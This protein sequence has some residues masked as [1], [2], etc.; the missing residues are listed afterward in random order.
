MMLFVFLFVWCPLFGILA[1]ALYLNH[2]EEVSKGRLWALAVMLSLYLGCLGVTKELLGDFQQYHRYFLEVPQ[3]D[4]FSYMALF[5]KEPVYYGYT[6]LAYYLFMGNWNLFVISITTANYLLLSYCLLK[7]GIYLHTSLGNMLVA[8]FF[9]AFFFQEFAAIGNMLRQGLAQSVTLAFLVRWHIDRKHS[10]WMALGAL[11]IHTSCLPIL[12]IGL[13]PVIRKRFR[14]STWMLLSVVACVGA[15]LFY[16]LGGFLSHLP[17]VGY[18]FERTANYEQLLAVDSW[19]TE[20]GL[21]PSMVILLLMLG[22]MVILLYRKW[23]QT[24]ASSVQ[25]VFVNLNL[26]LLLMM[27]VCDLLGMYYLL[28]RYFFYI[29][30]FQN[31]LLL[32]FLDQT[33]WLFKKISKWTVI[34]CM[35]VYFFYQFS[36]NI[37]SYIPVLEAVVFPLPV[38]LFI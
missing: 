38:Y 28:M 30:A 31:T 33:P 34:G 2:R 21:Q 18:I 22:C 29:Y 25:Y 3:Y 27:V 13:L 20:V 8:F 19:Q 14:L 10:W 4:L 15:I 1:Y 9:M 24:G 6:Y 36:H 35:I 26:V 17:F 11:G 5:G 12:A 7:L 32:V 23:S 16:F 37:F